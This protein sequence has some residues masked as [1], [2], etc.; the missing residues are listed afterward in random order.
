ML[1][2][3]QWIG[4]C[5]GLSFLL[6]LGFAMPLK[7]IWGHPEAVRVVGMAHGLL[8]MLYIGLAFQLAMDQKWP[9]HVLF[10]SFV[11]AVFPFGTFLFERKYLPALEQLAKNS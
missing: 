8:F 7:Y 4:R 2:L 6:L 9:K 3:F 10:R 11:A 1:R 5:E